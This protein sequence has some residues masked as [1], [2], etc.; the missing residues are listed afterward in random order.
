[1]GKIKFEYI[2]YFKCSLVS[3]LKKKGYSDKNIY[4]LIYNSNIYINNIVVRDKQVILPFKRTKITVYLNDEENTLPISK[5]KIDIAYEDEYFLIVN[6]PYNLDIEPTKRNYTNNLASKIS[7]YFKINNIKSKIHLVNRLDKLTTGLVIVA[8]NQYI[9]N[10]FKKVK[11]TKKYQALVKGK[12]KR[13][14]IIKINI[15]KD[16]TSIKR[17]EDM[18]G[19]LCISKYKLIKYENNNSLVDIL[20]KTGRT[21]QIRVSFKSINHPLANDPLYDEEATNERMYLKAYYL[22]FMH[23]ITKKRIIVTIWKKTEGL[24]L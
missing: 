16:A 18:K 8:K 11:I 14:G 1:M 9:H 22:S 2:S 5:N 19:K 6:K 24:V 12:T 10:L 15:S 20:I 23:P 4:Y 13:K 21:H 17:K 3:F 7:Y